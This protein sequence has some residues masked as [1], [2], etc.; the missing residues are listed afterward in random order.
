[1]Y[2]EY[3]LRV[4]N[5]F[6]GVMIVFAAII[7]SGCSTFSGTESTQDKYPWSVILVL[8]FEMTA[9]TIPANAV[10]LLKEDLKKEVTEGTP[11]QTRLI[12]PIE[13]FHYQ[14]TLQV[15]FEFNDYK[16]FMAYFEI[17]ETENVIN[18]NEIR[19][20]FFRERTISFANPWRVIFSNAKAAAEV[21][22]VI[23]I[24]N[25]RFSLVSPKPDHF[26]VFESSFR[27]TDVQGTIPVD[28]DIGV[29]NYVFFYDPAGLHEK[30]R[31]NIAIFD[32]FPN[33]PLWYV[34]AL[35]ATVLFISIMYIVFARKKNKGY[36]DIC[37]LQSSPTST[38]I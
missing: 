12:E 24:V 1:M 2:I 34:S 23:S 4:K 30:S 15:A 36:N 10:S 14:K 31:S 32:R 18:I 5:L 16:D 28:N 21:A 25:S 20:A 33:T 19:T 22:G 8:Q 35:G 13:V 11:P 7:F 27:R 3:N 37:R 38:E 9:E 29:Y 26:Y 6:C 17:A